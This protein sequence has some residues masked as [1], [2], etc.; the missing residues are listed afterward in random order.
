MVDDSV[1][2][3]ADWQLV[4]PDGRV[5]DVHLPRHVDALLPA[6]E[7]TYLLRTTVHVP[8]AMRGKDLTLALPLLHARTTLTAAGELMTPLDY[9]MTRGYR[10]V[11][12]S[13]YRIPARVS[14]LG[15]V[16]VV[17][18]VDYATILGSRLDIP[19]RLSAT[20]EGDRAF[21]FVRDFNQWTSAAASVIVLV[22]AFSYGLVYLR[23]RRRTPY[24][25]FALQGIAGGATY[26]LLMQGAFQFLVGRLEGAVAW[27]AALGVYSSVRFTHSFF[28][29]GPV[30]K[31]WNAAMIAALVV[32]AVC[33]AFTAHFWIVALVAMPMALV[34]VVYQLT[35]M[36]RLW[37]RDGPRPQIVVI[38]VS[39]LVFAV[40]GG[41][42]VFMWFGLGEMAGGM[43]TVPLGFAIIA[44]LQSYVLSREHHDAL[45]KAEE[46]NTELRRQIASRADTLAAALT[47]ASQEGDESRMLAPG[48]KI[49]DRYEIVRRVGEGAAGIVYE[50]KRPGDAQ[51]LALKLL[52]GAADATGMARFAREAQLI[53]QLDHPNVVRIVDVDVSR[54][55]FF[56]LVVEFVEGLSLQQH[57]ERFG[58]V[59]WAT[60]VLRQMAEGL[61]AIHARGIVHRDLKP[62]N[63]LVTNTA[64]G[65][66][67]VKIADFGIAAV[68]SGQNSITMNG[69][70]PDP[71]S[72]LTET[73]VWIGTPKYMAPELAAGAKVADHASDV[74]S[75]GVI[76]YEVLT[77]KLP[78]EGSAAFNQ[79]SGEPYRPPRPLATLCPALDE[80]IARLLDRCFRE[81]PEMRPEAAEI[82]RALG[83]G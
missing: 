71:S 13:A 16:P 38:F 75:L 61:A 48:D 43:R 46:L 78:Y 52:R 47:R 77:G 28:G 27:T 65:G 50:A 1:L 73:G 22:A 69:N 35:T 30:P 11:D 49:D 17:L 21:V 6:H 7:C 63:V 68:R 72:D 51:R 23:D 5:T 42:D 25:W 64:S 8:D 2:E 76:A 40:L 24:G 4:A 54:T 9:A 32:A 41:P 14:S 37:R 74:F 31:A 20:A 70:V 39:W 29:L 33:P 81:A 57:R 3:L 36:G 15:D 56:F 83:A 59:P 45:V 53:A 62:A 12:Q 34:N 19:P 82:A 26:A 60:S 80:K 44:M 18:G 10:G 58:D 67:L 79:I 55:G 66:T